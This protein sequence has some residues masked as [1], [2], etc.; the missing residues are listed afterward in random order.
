MKSLPSSAFQS[1]NEIALENG[2]QIERAITKT[3][4]R[5]A[6]GQE[7]LAQEVTRGRDYAHRVAGTQR[8]WPGPGGLECIP[9]GKFHLTQKTLPGR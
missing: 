2:R 4:Q 1:G 9:H 3:L 5:V 6:S 7:V 8:P